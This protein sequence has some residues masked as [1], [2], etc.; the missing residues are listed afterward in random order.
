MNHFK[1][2]EKKNTLIVN[3]YGAPG[4][5]KSSGAAYIFYKLKSLGIDAELVTEY[6]KDKVWE[7]HDMVF[8][9]SCYIFG[10]QHFRL[11]RVF[12]KVDVI[13][14]DAPLF[15]SAFYADPDVREE[16]SE[17]ARKTNAKYSERSLSFFVNRMKVYNPNGRFQ[18]KEESDAVAGEMRKFVEK[19]GVPL[20]DIPGSEAGYDLVVSETLAFLGKTDSATLYEGCTFEGERKLHYAIEFTGEQMETLRAWAEAVKANQALDKFKPDFNGKTLELASEQWK[21]ADIPAD[22]PAIWTDGDYIV[23]TNN[24]GNNE[25]EY[26]GIMKWL[27]CWKR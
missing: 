13:V 19:M 11:A 23:V 4:A 9:D 26:I 22:S 7:G 24:S 17:I 15:I 21:S 1:L 3:L 27:G 25:I 6:A 18:S 2:M 8:K 12:G 20:T 10:H 16:L 14:T 5:G